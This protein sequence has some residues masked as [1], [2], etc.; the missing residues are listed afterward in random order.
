MFS[1]NSKLSLNQS[2]LLTKDQLKD[3]F[4]CGLCSAILVDPVECKSCKKRFHHKC[5]EKF[6][7]ETGICPMQC[8]NTKFLSVKKSVEKKLQ[9]M[10]FKCRNFQMGCA[11]VLKYTDVAE[12]D[13][14]C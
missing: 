7:A 8:E 2:N 6:F 10:E 4:L 14:I 3:E 1:K 9:K 13:A 5:L 11:E 12:H